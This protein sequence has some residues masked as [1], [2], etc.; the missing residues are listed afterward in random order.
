MPLSFLLPSTH[1]NASTVSFEFI[2][3]VSL[4]CCC[5]CVYI[6]SHLWM[7]K[8]TYICT[9]A[10]TY[11]F[12]SIVTLVWICYL[13]L[14]FNDDRLVLDNWL[15]WSWLCRIN[16]PALRFPQWP[17]HSSFQWTKEKK[18]FH[19]S[20]T[21]HKTLNMFLLQDKILGVY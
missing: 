7:Y 18:T 9:R 19:E 3:S 13:Y 5:M 1:I 12:L 20:S 21:L 10:H 14:L 8:C 6:Y 11:I 2:V 16:F 15:V 4:N 17:L